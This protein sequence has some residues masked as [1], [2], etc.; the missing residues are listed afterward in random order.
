MDPSND[1]LHSNSNIVMHNVNLQHVEKALVEME[2]KFLSSSTFLAGDEIGFVD[3]I[4]SE[5]LEQVP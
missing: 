3:V 5:E 4:V 1:F 2:E